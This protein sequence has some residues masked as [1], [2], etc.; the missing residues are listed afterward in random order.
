LLLEFGGFGAVTT[1]Q[2]STL[3]LVLTCTDVRMGMIFKNLILKYEGTGAGEFTVM[4]H[5]IICIRIVIR[6]FAECGRC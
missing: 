6:S 4:G 3:T 1:N 5:T 2:G